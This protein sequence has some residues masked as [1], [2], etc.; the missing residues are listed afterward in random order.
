MNTFP[1]SPA[2]VARMNAFSAPPGTLAIWWLGQMG[3][4][5]KGQKTLLV[6][7]PYLSDSVASIDSVFNRAFP[8]PVAPGDLTNVDYVL[9][10]HEHGDHTDPLS[11]GPIGRASPGAKVVITGWSHG[12]MDEAGIDPARRIVAS[13][14]VMQLGEFKVTPVPS[15]HYEHECD[16]AKGE[17]W[18]GFMIEGNG[19]TLY[20]T[21]DT[22][23]YP[24]YVDRL[25]ALPTPD[26]VIAATNGRDAKRDALNITGNLYPAEA[27]WLAQTLGW[28][29]LLVGH[30]DLFTFNSLS[31]TAIADGIA[32]QNPRQRWHMLQPGEFYLAAR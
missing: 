20:H 8:S 31:I 3:V 24:G 12:L 21:G 23:I 2:L 18:L 32:R 26:V 19:V 29:T 4:A 17:R 25:R 22:I 7:D 15:A 27:A 28:G 10:S 13:D 14:A 6:I 16:P 1:D 30:N 5:V 9:C 11:V